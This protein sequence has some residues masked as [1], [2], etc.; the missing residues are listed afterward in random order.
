MRRPNLANALGLSESQQEKL[1]ALGLSNAKTM[2]RLQADQKIAMLDLRSAMGQASP[3]KTDVKTLVAEVNR[4]RGQIL[5]ARIDQQLA[6]AA[7]FTPEQKEKMKEL[8]KEGKG[9]RGRGMMQ[10]GHRMMRDGRRMMGRP[11][12]QPGECPMGVE[13]PEC[14]RCLPGRSSEDAPAEPKQ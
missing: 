14:P 13:C 8:R 9:H 6:R 5:T 10:R 7:V 2:A 4:A 3:S 11:H 12:M 1:K